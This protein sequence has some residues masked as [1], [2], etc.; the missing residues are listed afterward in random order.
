[1]LSNKDL[2]AILRSLKRKDDKKLPTKKQEMILLYHQWK[3]REPMQFDY[4]S[5]I[6]S[7]V[8]STKGVNEENNID[9]NNDE[10]IE[11]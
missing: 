6:G 7:N 9:V 8:T 1:M 4:S 2:T 11:I 3:D 10:V 5:V